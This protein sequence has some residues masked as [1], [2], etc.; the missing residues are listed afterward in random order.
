MSFRSLIRW[1]PQFLY[2]AGPK[3]G[4]PTKI[5]PDAAMRLQ[6]I[7]PGSGSRA[8]G[9]IGAEEMN[10]IED[11]NT[12]EIIM[13]RFLPFTKWSQV[14]SEAQYVGA[15]HDYGFG[16]DFYVPRQAAATPSDLR[17]TTMI[18]GNAEVEAASALFS[19]VGTR[20]HGCRRKISSTLAGVVFFGVQ[21]NGARARY[22]TARETYASADLNA[23]PTAEWP[24]FGAA[25]DEVNGAVVALLGGAGERKFVRLPDGSSPTLV[26]A[27]TAPVITTPST[28][29]PNCIAAGGGRAIAL[30]RGNTAF[31]AYTSTDGGVTWDA[32][33]VPRS[34]GNTI[35]GCAYVEDFLGLGPRFVFSG[36]SSSSALD[37]LYVTADGSAWDMITLPVGVGGQQCVILGDVLLAAQTFQLVGYDI[38][39]GK[40][41]SLIEFDGDSVQSIVDSGHRIYVGLASG[42]AIMSEPYALELD[43]ALAPIA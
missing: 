22:N 33:A 21:A 1:A 29:Q 19:N 5:Y 20:V 39:S 3:T 36:E 31:E 38:R 26:R 8:D 18:G 28:Q 27:T 17:K 42:V 32:V 16:R 41:V 7:R 6:G 23:S 30:F 40:I 14:S 25:Y 43:G 13:R 34:G 35:R 2:S 10:A 4:L 11:L 24:C 37:E 12:H 9:A 15:A